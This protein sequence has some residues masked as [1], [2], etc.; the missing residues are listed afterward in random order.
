MW[1]DVG[2][3]IYILRC[4]DSSL[5][6]GHTNDLEWRMA[7]HIAGRASKFTAERPPVEA[8]YTEP[9][10]D[11]LTAVARDRQIKGWTRAKK[12]ALI[13]GD[14][15]LLKAPLRGPRP[16]GLQRRGSRE[17]LLGHA[18]PAITAKYYAHWVKARQEGPEAAVRKIWA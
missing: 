12:E 6:V 18:T 1:W 4:A 3:C 11:R 13:A 2:W 5:Y 15:A 7:R 16:E 9:A 10:E 8:V 14:L 17:D